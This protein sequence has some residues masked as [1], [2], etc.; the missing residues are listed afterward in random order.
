MRTPLPRL[1]ALL[2]LALLMGHSAKSQTVEI[3]FEEGG[4]LEKYGVRAFLGEHEGYLYVLRGMNNEPNYTIPNFP[5]YILEA[6]PKYPLILVKYDKQMKVIN[7]TLLP[8][9]FPK[10]YRLIDDMSFKMLPDKKIHIIFNV[11]DENLKQNFATGFIFDSTGKALVHNKLLGN[12]YVGSKVTFSPDNSLFALFRIIPE[13]KVED[14]T[15][16]TLVYSLIESDFS[17]AI[18]AN[19]VNADPSF[20]KFYTW[21]IVLDD[22]ANVLIAMTSMPTKQ[23]K[24]QGNTEPY[25]SFLRYDYN[26]Q[27]K[28]IDIPFAN[29]ELD[30][31]LTLFDRKGSTYTALSYK[32]K[33]EGKLHVGLMFVKYELMS[34]SVKNL[35]IIELDT[36]FKPGSY[37]AK[38]EDLTIEDLCLQEDGSLL[39]TAEREQP[40]TN[41]QGSIYVFKLNSMFELEWVKTVYRNQYSVAWNIHTS[42]SSMYDGKNIYI[43]WNDHEDNGTSVQRKNVDM[44]KKKQLIPVLACIDAKTGEFVGKKQAYQKEGPDSRMLFV[45]LGS[46]SHQ[47]SNTAGVYSSDGKRILLGRIQLKR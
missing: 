33:H 38:L 12:A 24:K 23:D 11:Y 39:V 37:H 32:R 2:T 31:G 36:L 21:G 10:H 42:I 4:E 43:M 5:Q 29:A 6:Q 41:E 45:F 34:G 27:S 15:V 28:L 13:R 35:N 25:L 18:Q 9:D 44:S 14:K 40:T 46:L 8:I 7:K 16:T 22:S 19:V 30:N 20:Q 1:I 3:A 17:K 47:V 26:N